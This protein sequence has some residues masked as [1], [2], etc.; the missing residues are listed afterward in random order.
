MASAPFDPRPVLGRVDK[1]GRLIAADPELE[2]L[3]AE[4]GSRLGAPL[5]LPQLAAIARVAQRLRIPVSRR[6]LAAG[7]DQDVD[8]WVRAVPEGD[9][10]ALAIEQWSARP[11]SS[12]RLSAI[13]TVAHE[14]LEAEPLAWS[15]D[16]QLRLVSIAPELAEILSIDPAEAAGQPL[17]RLF[18]LEE[19]EDGEMPLLQGLASR[20]GFSGQRVRTRGKGEGLVLDAE[21]IIG[22][23]GDFAGFDGSAVAPDRAPAAGAA[24]ALDSAI[25]GALRSPLDSI[26]RSAEDMIE[27]SD[28]QVREKYAD[29]AS[30]IATAAR[31]LLSVVRSLGEQ[32]QAP[33]AD[34]VNLAK[35]ASD[36][37]ALVES[38]ASE[39]SIVIAVEPVESFPARGEARSVTQIL[40]NLIGNAVRYSAEGTAVTISFERSG[41]SALVHV[42]D[43]GP[44]IDLADQDR[45]FEPFQKVSPGG[46]GVGL[47]LAIARRLARAMDGDVRLESAPGQGARFTLELASA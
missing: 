32:S 23:D 35:L 22:A 8:M 11:A 16:D 14:K 18:R 27:R 12:P 10:I 17:T 2:R 4:A 47:G 44:G 3:Q 31:H 20:S 9:E 29:Y 39:R 37:V 34:Q 40:V 43:E 26:V 13:A 25:H 5:A 33:S 45:I 36:A 1:G 7:K 6:A 41:G 24:V 15:V 28:G 21:A 19:D 42:A 46:E 38:A 30:D